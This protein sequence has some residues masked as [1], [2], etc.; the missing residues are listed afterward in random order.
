L[1]TGPD[2]IPT[3]IILAEKIITIFYLGRTY[4]YNLAYNF[5]YLQ[6]YIEKTSMYNLFLGEK[7]SNPRWSK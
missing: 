1:F 7:I 6:K 2:P 4:M 3:T 5:F